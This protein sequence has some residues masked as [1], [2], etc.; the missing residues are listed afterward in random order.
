MNRCFERE[1]EVA[2]FIGTKPI[3]KKVSWT[4]HETEKDAERERISL[5]NSEQHRKKLNIRIYYRV[6]IYRKVYA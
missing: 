3:S 5:R 6:N 4:R 2:A 1:F